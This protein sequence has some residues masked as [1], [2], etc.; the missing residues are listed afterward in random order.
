MDQAAQEKVTLAEKQF[1]RNSTLAAA[2]ELGECYSQLIDIF[3]NP[4]HLSDRKAVKRK[5]LALLQWMKKNCIELGDADEVLKSL[6]IEFY[7]T[8]KERR[9]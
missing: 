6:E 5:L 9:I 2:Y 1:L 8:D 4:E 7:Y 3:F